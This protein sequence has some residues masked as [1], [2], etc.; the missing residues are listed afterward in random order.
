MPGLI[1]G[2]KSE[3]NHASAR[4]RRANDDCNVDVEHGQSLSRDQFGLTIFAVNSRKIEGSIRAAL[5]KNDP[6]R[7]DKT[8]AR[9]RRLIHSLPRYISAQVRANSRKVD[10]RPSPRFILMIACAASSPERRA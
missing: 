6:S 7:G 3:C 9:A 5:T 2:T 4:G 8:E 10:C 1:N